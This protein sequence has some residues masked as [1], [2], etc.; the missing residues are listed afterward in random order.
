VLLRR[1]FCAWLKQEPSR[2]PELGVK[3]SEPIQEDYGWGLWASHGKDRFWIALSYVVTARRN[4]PLSGIVS[5]TNDFG[6]NLAKRGLWLFPA[7]GGGF[8]FLLAWLIA[9][10]PRP[11]DVN[12][13]HRKGSP[14]PAEFGSLA[15]LFLPIIG[16]F[17]A[18]FVWGSPLLTN[19]ALQA[20]WI[21]GLVGAFAAL[22]TSGNTLRQVFK[23]GR[24][25]PRPGKHWQFGEQPT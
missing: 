17:V 6:L 23:H 19:E 15:P 3:L 20:G 16:V 11:L 7:I 2:F 4:R 14:S 1:G 22:A 21:R 10:L 18:F 8:A 25:P 24:R 9:K 13:P 12:A 5:V